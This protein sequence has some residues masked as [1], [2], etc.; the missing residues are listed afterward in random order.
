MSQCKIF[1]LNGDTLS[2][3]GGEIGVFEQ[4]DEVCLCNF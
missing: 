4:R 1:W 2:V 3:D